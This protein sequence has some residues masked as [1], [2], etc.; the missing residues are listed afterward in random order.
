M[1]G[2]Q[3]QLEEPDLVLPKRSRDAVVLNEQE[4]SHVFGYL[5]KDGA[6][7]QP[8]M[9]AESMGS[10]PANKDIYKFLRGKSARWCLDRK[11]WFQFGNHMTFGGVQPVY[12]DE[13]KEFL[14][15]RDIGALGLPGISEVS[16]KPYQG[17][18]AS[19]YEV[20]RSVKADSAA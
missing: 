9:D 16:R 12:S 4:Y 2:L 14:R 10:K 13:E 19:D 6:F 3:E 15:L 8:G 5:D 1:Q 7:N 18:T 11:A 17:L 20:W